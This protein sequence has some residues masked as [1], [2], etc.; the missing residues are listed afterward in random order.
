MLLVLVF[1]FEL[2]AQFSIL[3]L[4]EELDHVPV[5]DTR[6]SEVETGVATGAEKSRAGIMRGSTDDAEVSLRKDYIYCLFPVPRR[7][8]PRP[9]H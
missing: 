2:H 8:G 3:D 1:L 4:A 5:V 7:R 9:E 6:M